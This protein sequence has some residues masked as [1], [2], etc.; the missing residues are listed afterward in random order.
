MYWKNHNGYRIIRCQRGMRILRK[1]GVKL[2]L[3]TAYNLEA[4]GK[5]ERGYSPIVHTLVKACND[6]VFDWP[7]LWPCA[8]W[9]N[10]TT[11]NTVMGYHPAEL[12]YG[13]KIGNANWRADTE[14]DRILQGISQNLMILAI[15]QG[16][17]VAAPHML[18]PHRTDYVTQIDWKIWPFM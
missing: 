11:H 12:V 3:T 9:A 14:T 16:E 4:N 1:L 6:K 10:Q 2:A 7:K 17:H 18:I 13:Q 8:L 15:H 5:S